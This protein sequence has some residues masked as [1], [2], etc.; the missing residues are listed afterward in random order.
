MNTQRT[1]ISLV[2]GLFQTLYRSGVASET[3][4]FPQ[5]LSNIPTIL[6]QVATIQQ[7]AVKLFY[8]QTGNNGKGKC[9]CGVCG[10]V[11][12]YVCVCMWV[13]VLHDMCK[14]GEKPQGNEGRMRCHADF[15]HP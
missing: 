7:M 13:G 11:C 2:T 15:T 12:A 4:L 10:F 9:V 8:E 3:K 14:T 5:E 6:T 1:S